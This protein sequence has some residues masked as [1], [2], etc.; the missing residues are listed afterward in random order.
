MNYTD[1]V[2]KKLNDGKS[3]EQ[4]AKE[5]DISRQALNQF[6]NRHCTVTKVYKVKD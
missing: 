2:L 5:E 3:V 6:L 1:L 4:V